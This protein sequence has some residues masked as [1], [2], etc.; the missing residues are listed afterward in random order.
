MVLVVCLLVDYQDSPH[1]MFSLTSLHVV[2]IRDLLC[3]AVQLIEPK[4]LICST[5]ERIPHHLHDAQYALSRIV[6]RPSRRFFLVPIYRVY[7]SASVK[8][9]RLRQID[10]PFFT[11]MNCYGVLVQEDHP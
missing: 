5:K 4:A 8:S 10:P 7:S 11:S 3:S 9:C 1:L 6:C 2:L